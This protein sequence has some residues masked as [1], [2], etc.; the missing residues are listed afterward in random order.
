MNKNM[1]RRATISVKREGDKRTWR[2]QEQLYPDVDREAETL[3]AGGHLMCTQCNAISI[4]KH[5]SFDQA[6]AAKLKT[7]SKVHHVL[8]PGCQALDKEEFEGEVILR[9]PLADSY[10]QGLLGL[11]KHTEEHCRQDNP[12][13]RMKVLQADD[14]CIRLMTTTRFLATRIGKEVEK[15]FK[16]HTETT[17][18]PR[19]RFVRIKWT[20]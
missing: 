19:D 4:R 16:G 18:R 8:C 6:L 14:E 7:D 20:K 9:G 1:S 12:Q 5:W 11:I 3:K 2:Q 10:A 13:A 15:A 17:A